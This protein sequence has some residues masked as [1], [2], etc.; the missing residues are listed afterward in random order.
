MRIPQFFANDAS[1]VAVVISRHP[2]RQERAWGAGCATL[3]DP[4][5]ENETNSFPGG[6]SPRSLLRRTIPLIK[7]RCN[8]ATLQHAGRLVYGE[9]FIG[10]INDQHW[11]RCLF[12]FDLQAYLVRHCGE[13]VRNGR[14]RMNRRW[15]AP[16]FFRHVFKSQIVITLKS[17][18]VH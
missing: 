18:F 11:D 17:C 10:A 7:I 8:C 2:T 16:I 15:G 12:G 14:I 3:G 1:P 9:H 13:D 4:A 6:G 5:N